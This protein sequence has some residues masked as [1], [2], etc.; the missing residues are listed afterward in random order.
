[1]LPSSGVDRYQLQYDRLAGLTR[2]GI[3]LRPRVRR[4]HRNLVLSQARVVEQLLGRP[5]R[6]CFGF[7]QQSREF[8]HPFRPAAP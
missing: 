7:S 4:L 6:T 8:R 5:G 3:L 1:M 2:N